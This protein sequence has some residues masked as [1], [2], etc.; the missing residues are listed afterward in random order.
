M[1]NESPVGALAW[2][3]TGAAVLAVG[4]FVG[5]AAGRRKGSAPSERR[6]HPDRDLLEDLVDRPVAQAAQAESLAAARR[7]DSLAETVASLETRVQTVERSAVTDRVD[8]LWSRVMQLEERLE[9]IRAMEIP[10]AD[11]LAARV[12]DRLAP[13]LAVL[14]NRVEEHQTAIEQLQAHATQTE[15][16]LQKMIA[17]VEKL[18]E[19]ISRSLP[20][21]RSAEPAPAELG[22][23]AARAPQP[24]KSGPF[25]W[26]S[27]A[28]AALIALGMVGSWA[29]APLQPIRPVR[30]A[31]VVS[32]A[33][34]ASEIDAALASVSRPIAQQPEYPVWNY[35]LGRLYARKQDG[36][37]AERWHRA[38]LEQNPQDERVLRALADVMSR[39]VQ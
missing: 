26:K 11:A 15:A 20:S 37:P 35:E 2:M 38:G 10:P 18:T 14:E 1:R 32:S 29:A 17:A 23:P 30:A 31:N 36:A 28:L 7:V 33:P 5:S 9:Q 13:R 6:D 16:N 27:Q 24:E 3:A 25:R 21:S 4:A 39:R 12:Q 8:A 19:Q 22:A 34:V